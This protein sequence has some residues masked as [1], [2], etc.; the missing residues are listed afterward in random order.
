MFFFGVGSIVLAFLHMNF[1]VLM[2]ID[3]A[4]P[5]VGWAI[6]G[7]LTVI[8]GALWVVGMMMQKKDG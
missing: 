7:G 8:G 1:I 3:A 5:L 6:R 2:W 4:G